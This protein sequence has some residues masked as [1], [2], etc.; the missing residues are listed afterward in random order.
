MPYFY[1]LLSFSISW[2]SIAFCIPILWHHKL[3]LE[4]GSHFKGWKFCVIK[5]YGLIRVFPVHRKFVFLSIR[6]HAHQLRTGAAPYLLYLE[7]NLFKF[8]VHQ[9]HWLTHDSICKILTNP[10]CAAYLPGIPEI[11]IQP[12]PVYGFMAVQKRLYCCDMMFFSMDD[13]INSPRS[14]I[15]AP[16]P[17]VP[18]ALE[19][20][21]LSSMP[22]QK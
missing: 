14:A 19:G 22:A 3:S 17:V 13:R 12:F 1:A 7:P 18:M 5:S 11:F 21:W 15:T 9:N 4:A 6:Q 8:L 20:V 10:E 2:I 16:R